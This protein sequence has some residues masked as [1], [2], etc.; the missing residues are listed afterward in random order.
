[1]QPSIHESHDIVAILARLDGTNAQD[2]AEAFSAL[3]NFLSATC[4]SLRA[5]TWRV[6]YVLCYLKRR[7]N[8]FA[9]YAGGV[10]FLPW[11]EAVTGYSKSSVYRMVQ[12][13]DLYFF[14]PIGQDIVEQIGGMQQFC[15]HVPP[16]KAAI[17][18]SVIAQAAPD[19]ENIQEVAEALRDPYV[20][21]ADMAATFLQDSQLPSYNE[22]TRIII[23]PDGT[24]WFQVLN[25]PPEA[26]RSVLRVLNILHQ[27]RN[28]L[29]SPAPDGITPPQLTSRAQ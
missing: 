15:A 9:E 24:P 3:E 26:L 29:E 11:A 13:A 6:S 25:P 12:L 4:A 14:T 5:D 7:W 1:M 22:E 10:D 20:S 16:A 8:V 2:A 28:H 27:L 17:A 19:A 21:A 18:T 23:G